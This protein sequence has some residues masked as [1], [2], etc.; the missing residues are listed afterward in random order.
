MILKVRFFRTPCASRPAAQRVFLNFY[1]F[2]YHLKQRPPW[3]HP[4]FSSPNRCWLKRIFLCQCIGR[5]I[6]ICICIYFVFTKLATQFGVSRGVDLVCSLACDSPDMSSLLSTFSLSCFCL[7]SGS[8]LKCYSATELHIH[9]LQECR[10]SGFCWQCEKISSGWE[11]SNWL[12]FC[13]KS[14]QK[15]F[16][17]Y[18][19]F[20]IKIDSESYGDYNDS[21]DMSQ[22]GH[23]DSLQ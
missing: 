12:F 16:V 2:S 17:F 21:D 1:L 19:I 18:N 15:D 5:C 11:Y 14:F 7:S 13:V 20:Y 4:W 8:I 22:Q 10:S 3:F 9:C 6:R 23:S